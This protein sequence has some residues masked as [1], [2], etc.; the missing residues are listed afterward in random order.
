[1]RIAQL[2]SHWIDA[3]DRARV[4]TEAASSATSASVAYW[5]VLVLAGAIASLGLA[6]N[7]S[8]VI[9]GAMLIAP[10]LAP[11]VG[12]AL[13]LA[14]GDGGLAV[15]TLL[16]V[17]VST[18]AVI[19]VG[20]LLALALPLPFQIV[21]PEIAARTR[22]TTLD[23]AIAVASGLAGAAVTVSPRSRLSGA[24]PGVA[25]SVALVPPL[26]VTGYGIGTGWQWPIIRGSLLLYGANLAG[27][28]MSAMV[29]FLLAGMHQPDVRR[30]DRT[31]QTART[32][33]PLGVFLNRVPAL[34]SLGVLE[35]TWTRVALVVGFV[36]LVAIPL[37]ESLKQIARESR[38]KAAV[39]AATRR[40]VRA[41]HSFVVGKDVEIGA[42]GTRVVLDVATTGW[43]SDSARVAFEAQASNAAGESVA[44]VLEQLPASAGD[45]SSFASMVGSSPS[46]PVSTSPSASAAPSVGSRVSA[47]RGTVGD[48]VAALDLPDSVTALGY[49]FAIGDSTVA[50]ATDV[51]YAAPR[52][53]P[54]EAAELVTRQLRRTLAIDGLEVT[55][56]WITTAP[57]SVR[58]GGGRL[59]ETTAIAP[60][61][62][63][64]SLLRRYSRL[65]AVVVAGGRGRRGEAA[66]LRADSI[67]QRLGAGPPRVTI[68]WDTAAGSGVTVRT[69]VR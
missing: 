64:A 52:P 33:G 62:T 4:F 49:T 54:A 42:K 6:L 44:L 61:D 41:G 12:V 1:M 14:V 11:V 24:V 45:L 35:R 57:R 13:A 36:A 37:R 47:L 22:P 30:A 69:V 53:L 40:F 10:L 66:R 39:D 67:A 31:W 25:I 5:L 8:A 55:L 9:I 15:E 16:V 68:E 23:L 58:A 27:I 43:F 46:A 48:A 28:V 7:S 60:I 38:V 32:V 51:T 34:R 50:P 63:V 3:D 26:A 18:M 19:I 2:A 59:S 65:G 17:L 29:V 56:S 21:T 20:A